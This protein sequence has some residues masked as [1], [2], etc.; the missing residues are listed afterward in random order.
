M[1]L[2]KRL[3]TGSGLGA[4]SGNAAELVRHFFQT[5]GEVDLPIEAQ[6][7]ASLGADVAFLAS[8]FDLALADGVGERLEGLDC[9]ERGLGLKTIV[10]IPGWSSGTAEAYAALDR[11]RKAEA[12]PFMPMSISEARNESL[13][14]LRRLSE[15]E[16]VGPLPNDFIACDSVH[17]GFYG[18]LYGVVEDAGALAWGLCGSGSSCFALFDEKKFPGTVS[19]A[20]SRILAE[21][22]SRFTWLHKTLVLE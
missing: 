5:S 8:A 10:F 11:S 14:V 1:K 20:L 2:F 22:S 12:F 4:G 13:G 18:D 6:K 16:I 17:A 3:P 15:G 21:E 7:I 19:R 9:S